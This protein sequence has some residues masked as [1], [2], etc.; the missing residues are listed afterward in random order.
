MAILSMVKSGESAPGV[1]DDDRFMSI[2]PND[3]V[4]I[5]L[6]T[7][8]PESHMLT[9]QPNNIISNQNPYTELSYD[10]AEISTSCVEETEFF[11]GT[12]L[13]PNC[14][15]FALDRRSRLQ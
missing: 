1:P 9:H 10:S 12:P 11:D 7:H 2:L 4:P 3:L 13:L 5:V 8:H 14:C 15:D 6:G